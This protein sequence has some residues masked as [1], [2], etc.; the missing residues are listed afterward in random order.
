MTMNGAGRTAPSLDVA[1]V[2][3]LR[4]GAAVHLRSIRPDDASSL[5]AFSSRLSPRTIYQRFFSLRPLRLEDAVTLATV[6]GHDRVAIVAAREIGRAS[7][8]VG[9][10]EY[11][12]TGDDLIPDVGL[13]VED[14]WQGLGLGTM[15]L[16]EIMRAGEQRGFST[17]HG[18]ILAENARMLRLL[19]RYAQIVERTRDHSVI[20]LLFRR[21]AEA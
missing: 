2:T 6:D 15:L 12:L 3:T 18:E 1:R 9:V 17:F 10:A 7:E 16:A 21:P 19:F 8:L 4:N 11:G 5:M 20:T 14:T 13:V